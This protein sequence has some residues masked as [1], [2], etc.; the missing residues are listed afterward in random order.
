MRY[1]P[2]LL[3]VCMLAI[4]VGCGHPPATTQD[5]GQLKHDM[6]AQDGVVG[7][8]AQ[9]QAG[10]ITTVGQNRQAIRRIGGLQLPVS[11]DDNLFNTVGGVG[12]NSVGGV[13]IVPAELGHDPRRARDMLVPDTLTD[14]QTGR[15]HLVYRRYPLIRD[16]SPGQPS[17]GFVPPPGG[18]GVPPRPSSGQPGSGGRPQVPPT[19]SPRSQGNYTPPVAPSHTAGGDNTANRGNVTVN[20]HVHRDG[21]VTQGTDGKTSS[22]G[23]ASDGVSLTSH[24]GTCAGCGIDAA[25]YAL[26]NSRWAHK[27]QSVRLVRVSTDSDL[28]PAV[29]KRYDYL[30]RSAGPRGSQF[31]F[32]HMEGAVDMYFI[33]RPARGA[34]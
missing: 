13:P 9:N 22:T 3:V 7:Q 33:C 5:V 21:S 4:V 15:T 32:Y 14:R 30:P 20:V 17:G 26:Q 19:A 2:L 12:Q 16:G 8:L 27:V 28:P 6:Y 29:G 23:S 34:I 31:V 1:L 11:S 10:L 18:G 25:T 24:T